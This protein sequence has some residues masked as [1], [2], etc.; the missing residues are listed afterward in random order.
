MGFRQKRSE[1][2][3]SKMYSGKKLVLYP[4]EEQKRYIEKS[5]DL[6]RFVYNWT[7]EQEQIQYK[8]FQNGETD[9]KF[10]RDYDLQK[11]LSELRNSTP[12]LQEVK[13]GTLRNAMFDAIEAYDKFFSRRYHNKYPKFK[14]KKRSVKMFRPRLDGK[15]YFE[16]SKVRIEGLPIGDK[17]ETKW[18]SGY[19]KSDNIKYI[20][21]VI[22][23]DTTGNYILSFDREVIK[24]CYLDDNNNVIDNYEYAPE[25]N[26]AIGIDLNVKNLIVTSYNNGEIFKAPNVSRE[27]KAIKRLQRKCQNDRKRYKQIV[28]NLERTN[29][30]INLPDKSKRSQKREIK[31]AKKYRRCTNIYNDYIRKV[32]KEIVLRKPVAIV[33][34][35]LQIDLMYKKHYLASNIGPFTPFRRIRKIFENNCDKYGVPVIIAP[36][37]Y[38]SSQICSECGHEKHMGSQKIYVCHNCG[39]RKNRDINAAFNLE[40]LCYN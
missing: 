17:I 9:K 5:I 33:L 30:D 26:R 13:L 6:Y 16:G 38:R 34:E 3:K 8:L 36:K 10:L 27:I 20:N 12:W 18:D 29:P 15:F 11:R 19:Q 28:S 21:A 32:S 24:P 23:L 25:Y 39:A 37:D 7:L 4:T 35:D 1:K 40:N 31:L 14:S 2:D 22:K